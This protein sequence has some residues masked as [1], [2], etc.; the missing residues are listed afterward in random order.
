[1]NLQSTPHRGST[2]ILSYVQEVVDRDPRPGRYILTGSQQ[3]GLHEAVSQTLAGRTAL[4]QLL[5]L[6]L[7]EIRRFPKPPTDLW[8][9]IWTGGYPRIYN[10]RLPADEWLSSYAATYRM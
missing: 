6:D 10:R 1:M 3:L 8:T 4:L 7:S 9:L 5:P 2:E